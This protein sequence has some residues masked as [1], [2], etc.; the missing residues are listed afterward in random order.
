MVALSKL[1]F[2]NNL[3]S[4]FDKVNPS[5]KNK[6]TFEFD[7]FKKEILTKTET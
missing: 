5:L 2:N 6:N 7:I 1:N 4:N 3:I